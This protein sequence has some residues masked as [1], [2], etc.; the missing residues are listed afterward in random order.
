[1]TFWIAVAALGLSLLSLAMTILLYWTIPTDTERK[2]FI[3]GIIEM[4]DRS[5][6][7]NRRSS[8]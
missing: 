3:V 6:P 4:Y 5:R 1:M 2:N 7:F 8:R